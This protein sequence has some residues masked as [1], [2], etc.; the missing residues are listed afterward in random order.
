MTGILCCAPWS[1]GL[2]VVG[3]NALFRAEDQVAGSSEVGG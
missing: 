2:S 1:L 3:L